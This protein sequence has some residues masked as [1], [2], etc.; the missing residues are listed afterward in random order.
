MQVHVPELEERRKFWDETLPSFTSHCSVACHSLT[1]GYFDEVMNISIEIL[2]LN[3]NL[4][5]KKV[6]GFVY[7]C[8][9]N[10]H[11]MSMFK[12]YI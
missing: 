7:L 10:D 3:L 12:R 9:L 5:L 11:K 1:S 6:L 2:N 4:N 8:I